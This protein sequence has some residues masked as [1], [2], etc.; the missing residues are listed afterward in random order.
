[1]MDPVRHCDLYKDEGCAHVDGF[2]C[3]FETCS[4]RLEYIGAPEKNFESSEEAPENKK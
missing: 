2:L 3:D 1:M 4:M